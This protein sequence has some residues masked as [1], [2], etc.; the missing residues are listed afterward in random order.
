MKYAI[1]FFTRGYQASLCPQLKSDLYDSFYVALTKKDKKYLLS[2][3]EE[4][5]FCF[6][7]YLEEHLSSN[8]PDFEGEMV[9]SFYSDRFWYKYNLSTRKKLLNIEFMF[10]CDVLNYYSPL[11]VVN[12]IIT[13][14]HAEVLYLVSMQ[15]NVKYWG[16]LISP[17][18]DRPFYWPSTPFNSS[19]QPDVLEKD[20]TENAIICSKNYILNM[21]YNYS[22]PYYA[23]NKLKWMSFRN[24]GLIIVKLIHHLLYYIISRWTVNRFVED[25][26]RYSFNSVKLTWLKLVVFLKYFVKR[27]AYS[28]PQEEY[29]KV[30]FPLHYEPEATL[31]YFAEF[32][33]EQEQVILNISKLLGKNQVLIVKEHPQQPGSLLQSKFQTIL[34]K[35]S[36]VFFVRAEYPTKTLINKADLIITI[37]SSMGWESIIL[38]KKVVVFGNV[39][40]DKH[41]CVYKFNGNWVELKEKVRKLDF[42]IP[43]EA[44]NED[45]VAKIWSICQEGLPFIHKNLYTEDNINKLKQSIENKVQQYVASFV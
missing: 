7:E 38:E 2:I 40:Y 36:N 45:Y 26:D 43:S 42:N 20:V 23:V 3:N 5:K 13:V 1:L 25:Y 44:I 29:Q 30:I 28:M 24:L 12:E 34:K 35:T 17:F 31:F 8:I 9:T 15:K 21:K 19:L 10:W 16:W 41:P 11:A 27:K 6:E 37:S 14:E 32:Y 33:Q 18:K 4:V 39:F 22:Q